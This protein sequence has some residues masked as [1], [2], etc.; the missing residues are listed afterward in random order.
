M[1]NEAVI[2]V[3]RL[4]TY[5]YLDDNRV[6][7]AV[8][9][10]SFSVFPAETVAI[11]GESGSGKS[12]TALSIM[13]LISNPGKIVEGSILMN[14]EDLIQLSSKEMTRVRGQ[15]IAMIFQ[16]PMT[17]L[18]PVFTI[19]TQIIEMLRKHKKMKKKEA[20]AEAIRLLAM[21]GI[22][23]A[24]ELIDE[25]PHKLSGG[26]RQRVMIA[27]AISCNPKLLIADEPTTA[28]DVTIQA[29]ILTLL[30][31]MGG[32]LEMSVLMI[33]HDL[34]VVSDYADRVLVMY[35]AQIV[36]QAP[37]KELL[38]KTKHPYTQGLLKSMPNMV[39]EVHRLETI[40]GV[41]PAAY[42][43]PHG[44]R[45]AA[46]CPSVMEKCLQENPQLVEVEPGHYVRCHLY[47]KRGN[48][49]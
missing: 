14:D 23:R 7:K 12:M 5:F 25:Y 38:R 16:E 17:A 42:D 47:E 18:N 46:R 21:V 20:R 45:F 48:N 6:A 28:L 1:K 31:E 11:V 22:A 40:E 37:T 26:M 33:T 3:R 49:A 8:D 4:K 44:C 10:V 32:K 34:G 24:D 19:G 35:G 15:E 41:V 39:D 30:K 13:K 2:D 27:I 36:E 43:F 29:Q 9:D